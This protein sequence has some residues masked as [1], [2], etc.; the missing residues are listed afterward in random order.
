MAIKILSALLIILI[1]LTFNVWY[2]NREISRVT[3][4]KTVD[5]NV[6]ID[7]YGAMLARQV[8]Q[9][10]ISNDEMIALTTTFI[11]SLDAALKEEGGIIMISQSVISGGKDIT[12]DI[13]QKIIYR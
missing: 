12:D 10:R 2:V 13:R 3:I 5:I 8:E 11:N 7:N 4:I 1:I 9:G 6:L